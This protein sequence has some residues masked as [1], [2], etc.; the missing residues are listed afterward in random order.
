MEIA[1]LIFVKIL[2]I[3]D[4]HLPP[5]AYQVTITESGPVPATHFGVNSLHFS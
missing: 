3:A 2:Y 1:S 4:L 5:H